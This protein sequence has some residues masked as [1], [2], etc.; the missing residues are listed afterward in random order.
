M[1]DKNTIGSKKSCGISYRDMIVRVYEKPRRVILLRCISSGAVIA[2]ALLFAL[3]LILSALSVGYVYAMELAA[4]AAVPFVAVS[5][6]RKIINAP[7]PYELIGDFPHRPK[8][9][10]GES[11]PSRHTFSAF[12][13]ATLLLPWSVAVGA[14]LYAVGAL[15]AAARVLLGIHFVRDVTAGAAVGI[16]SG[17]IGIIIMNLI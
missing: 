11:F 5:V 9:K 13:I 10:S 6:L 16:I 1:K 8:N 15:L 12:L 3:R 4:V 7:R 14:S 2:V 17:I